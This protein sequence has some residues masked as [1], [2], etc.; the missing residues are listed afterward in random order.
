DAASA[1]AAADLERQDLLSKIAT[2]EQRVTDLESST[3]LSEPE[4]RVRRVEVYVDPNGQEHDEPVP[5]A[6]KEVTYR[7]ERTYRRQTISENITAS[8]EDAA[9]HSVTVG[10][11]AAMATH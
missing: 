6:K 4:T 2:L 11:D 8:L 3:V 9:T 5:G 7:R 10:V 1:A